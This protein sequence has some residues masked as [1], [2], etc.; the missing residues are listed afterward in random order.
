MPLGPHQRDHG[1]RPGRAVNGDDGKA[2]ITTPRYALPLPGLGVQAPFAVARTP[3]CPADADATLTDTDTPARPA[4]ART[5]LTDTRAPAPLAADAY[6]LGSLTDAR[7]LG[8]LADD[9]ATAFLGGARA[10]AFL[11]EARA[12]AFLWE[13]RAPAVPA[14]ACVPARSASACALVSLGD[15]RGLALLVDVVA[16]APVTNARAAALLAVRGRTTAR[17]GGR[18]RGSLTGGRGLALLSAGAV[19]GSLVSFR[20]PVKAAA[21][22]VREAGCGRGGADRSGRPLGR[23]LV[24]VA[25]AGAG[26]AT[27]LVAVRGARDIQGV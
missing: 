23:A 7:A 10:P 21:E 25:R 13:A 27:G 2:A 20:E 17:V 15:A 12:P 14:N 1:K 8:S 5:P 19:E 16:L 26:R 4:D 18:G 9:R 24:P 22:G 11:W 3:A 6:G